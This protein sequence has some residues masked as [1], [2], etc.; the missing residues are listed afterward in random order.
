MALTRKASLREACLEG[1]TGL[2]V[3]T[4][5]AWRD[6]RAEL[7]PHEIRDGV[8]VETRHHPGSVWID[9]LDTQDHEPG[10]L[11]RGVSFHD[12]LNDFALPERARRTVTD[13]V[14]RMS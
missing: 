2:N 6:A 3:A 13:T 10:D 7:P 8:H 11:L 9:G 14:R 4:D 1:G 12:D 5:S